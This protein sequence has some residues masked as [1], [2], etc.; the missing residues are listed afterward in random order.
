MLGLAFGFNVN[1]D[2]AVLIV[3]TGCRFNPI[4]DFVRLI[5]GHLDGNDEVELDKC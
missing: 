5:D 3:A 1:S 2:P 4:A